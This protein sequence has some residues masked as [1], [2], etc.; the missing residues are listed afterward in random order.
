MTRIA[1]VT[2]GNRGIGLEVVRLLARRGDTVVMG[3][4]DPAQDERRAIRDDPDMPQY[5]RRQAQAQLDAIAA[6]M[7][8]AREDAARRAG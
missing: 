4:R 7:E 6:L 2:G 8:A 3:S 1:V 5:P